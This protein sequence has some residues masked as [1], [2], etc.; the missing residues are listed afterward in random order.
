MD[1]TCYRQSVP[2]LSMHV[3]L[4]DLRAQC[5]IEVTGVE[6]YR[7]F[8]NMG[9]HYGPSFQT[10]EHLWLGDN[11]ALGRVRVPAHILSSLQEY[12]VHPVVLDAC[13]Q[14]LLAISAVTAAGGRA[15][16]EVYLP[17]AAERIRVYGPPAPRMWCHAAL[18]D[19]QA[20]FLEG[21]IVLCD[22][23]GNVLIAIEGFRVRTLGDGQSAPSSTVRPD[24]WLYQLEWRPAQAVR[25][26]GEAVEASPDGG[27]STGSWLIFADHD[28]VGERLAAVLEAR[29]QSCI[30]VFPGEAFSA[31][32]PGCYA[33][34]P[35][36]PEDYRHLLSALRDSSVPPCRGVVHLWSLN[37]RAATDIDADW[38]QTMQEISTYS[39][40]CLVQALMQEEDL[41]RLWLV[42][43]GAQSLG[44]E[45]NLPAL[46]QTPLWGLGRGV[47]EEFLA[48]RGALVDLDPAPAS[49]N[50]AL[51]AEEIE[52][53]DGEYQV[54]FRANQRYVPRLEHMRVPQQVLPPSFRP[55][56]SYLITGGLGALGCIVARW[57]VQRGARHLILAGRTK[58]PPRTMWQGIGPDHPQ[59]GSIAQ[60]RELEA[61]GATVHLAPVDITDEGQLVA[62]LERYQQE[63]WPSIRGVIHAAGVVQDQILWHMDRETFDKALRPKMLGGWALH[64]CLREMPLDF[65]IAFSSIVSLVVSPGQSNYA[66]GNAFLDA[67]AHYRRAQGLPAISI[68]W[69]PWAAGMIT[70]LQ[71]VD[72]YRQRGMESI[73]PDVGMRLLEHIYASPQAQVLVASVHWPILFEVFPVTP[74]LIRHLG[75]QEETA[76][77]SEGEESLTR[78]LQ[79]VEGAERLKLLEDYLAE[80][81]ARVL[82]IDPQRLDRERPLNTMGLDSMIAIELKNHIERGIAISPSVVDLL[83]GVSIVQLATRLAQQSQSAAPSQEEL[84][85]SV[86]NL[87]NLSEQVDETL[88]EQLLQQIEQLSP[89]EVK[90]ELTASR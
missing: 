43:R 71:L 62:F 75:E 77:G 24:V 45:G 64:H 65:F 10:I 63:C 32:A 49:D 85:T 16:A 54:A 4:A 51:L 84:P 53:S 8:Q 70:R 40:L 69:G 17:I 56:A 21:C 61:L 38:L 44:C 87:D 22:D 74:P 81:A 66:A 7:Q 11:Q 89:D 90:V 42:T 52:Q 82:R 13:F 72:F 79:R 48:L 28:G 39:V 80:T 35:G 6:C 12:H 34:Q 55:D 33:L 14:M 27:R 18:I 19:Q 31:L 50:V 26:A 36:Q 1:I 88:L 9:F 68:N 41:P 2:V 23:D 58:L 3:S 67:L 5:A 25:D 78:K 37:D 46:A 60:I 73:S 15:Q 29:G 47:Y 59:A 76:Q 30:L 20:A 83:Q 86:E 57:M